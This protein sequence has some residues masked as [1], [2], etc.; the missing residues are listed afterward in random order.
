MTRASFFSMSFWALFAA[1]LQTLPPKVAGQETVAGYLDE[2]YSCIM[3]HTAMRADFLEGVHARRGIQCTDCHGGDPS[4]FEADA[5]HSSDFQGGL[6]KEE[7]VELCLSC[8]GSISEMRQFALEPV[9]REEYLE[10][11][12][13]QR[14]LVE[15]DT[16]APSCSDCH[17]AHAILPRVEPRSPVNPR[18]IPETCARCHSDP[19]RFG[20]DMGTEQFAEW[21]TSAHGIGLLEG[22]NDRSA[23]CADCHGSHTALVPGV[24]EIPNVCGK[25]HQLVREAYF[26]G[27][28]REQIAA[29]TREAGCIGC[30]ENHRTEMPPFS[31]IALICQDCHDPGSPQATAGLELQEQTLRAEGAGERAR[32]AVEVLRTSGERTADEEIRLQTVETHLRE[33]LVVAHSLD[34]VVVEDLSRRISSISME[35]VERAEAVEEHRWERQLL[36]IPVWILVLG[37][38]LL[39]LRKSRVLRQRDLLVP[40][41]TGK[42]EDR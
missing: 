19:G 38:V 27:A 34:P 13:G 15:G 41:P 11:R 12:H 32:E 21:I 8:H 23:T 6:T 26:A 7:S 22:H 5:S 28:H 35:I 9:T 20:G 25:C 1:S 30:H 10:S 3:C 24:R 29:A 39:A 18:R 40:V 33:L 4:Q 36:A 2:E 14:L 31:D 42:G 37:G 17:G 16:L